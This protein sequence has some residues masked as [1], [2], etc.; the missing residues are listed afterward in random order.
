MEPVGENRRYDNAHVI[1]RDF[2]CDVCQL[3]LL[4]DADVVLHVKGKRHKKACR[5]IASQSICASW[6][7][8]GE[9]SCHAKEYHKG[10]REEKEIE[11]K[12]NDEKDS[13]DHH[14]FQ[15]KRYKQQ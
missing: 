10:R 8:E 11:E 2:Y 12:E 3:Q 14:R 1:A 15:A 9:M 6:S 5:T 4:S 13:Y 7:K